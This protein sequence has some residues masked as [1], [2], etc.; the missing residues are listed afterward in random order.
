MLLPAAVVAP[1][2]A[3][4]DPFQP[5]AHATA[6]QAFVYALAPGGPFYLTLRLYE[7]KPAAPNGEWKPP[8]ITFN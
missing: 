3:K 6:V 1:P 7:P 4:P 8:L 5:L 2:A